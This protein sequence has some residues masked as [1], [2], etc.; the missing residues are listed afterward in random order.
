MKG[1]NS[2]FRAQRTSDPGWLGRVRQGFERWRGA[3]DVNRLAEFA[4]ATRRGI[5]RGI[6]LGIRLGIGKLR[7]GLRSSHS[8]RCH[9]QSCSGQPQ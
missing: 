2:T 1:T 3:I 7:I 6:R 9:N 5:R 4:F 8:S